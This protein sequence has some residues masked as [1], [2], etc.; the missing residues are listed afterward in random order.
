MIYGFIPHSSGLRGTTVWSCNG[1]GL[2]TQGGPATI[3][4]T[5]VKE[6]EM[7]AAVQ[8]ISATHIPVGWACF[9]KLDTR[10]PKCKDKKGT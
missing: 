1:C 2:T 5:S 7:V 4:P 8:Q 10:C 6:R 9:G 3:A